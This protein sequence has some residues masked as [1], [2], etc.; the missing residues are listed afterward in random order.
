MLFV[1]AIDFTRM[2]PAGTCGF[3]RGAARTSTPAFET[4]LYKLNK[5][6]LNRLLGIRRR[7]KGTKGPYSVFSPL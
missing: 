6:L 1:I 5:P 4:S 7:L 3:I 2:R